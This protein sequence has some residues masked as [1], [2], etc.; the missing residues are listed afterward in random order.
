MQ[1]ALRAL[2]ERGAGGCVLVGDPAFYSRFGFKPEAG[3]TLP[4]VPPEFFQALPLGASMARGVVTFH[5][6]FTDAGM[7]GGS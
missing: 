5:A 3:L 4:D 7:Q 1:A 6:A 2:R